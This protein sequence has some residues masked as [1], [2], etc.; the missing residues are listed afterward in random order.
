MIYEYCR[1]NLV[2]ISHVAYF[3]EQIS[4]LKMDNASQSL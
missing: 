4:T 2:Y 1:N 3:E